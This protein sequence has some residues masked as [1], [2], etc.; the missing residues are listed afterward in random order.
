MVQL[1]NW[2]CAILKCSLLS[3]NP[4]VS[5][6][7]GVASEL[8]DTISHTSVHKQLGHLHRCSASCVCVCVCVSYRSVRK[9]QQNGFNHLNL[10]LNLCTTTPDIKHFYVS[11]A[12]CIY[13]P[14]T[15]LTTKSDYFLTQPLSE[16]FIFITKTC[17]VYRAV[18]NESLNTMHVNIHLY[19]LYH[20]SGGQ[21]SA[22]Y[23]DVVGSIPCHS[24]WNLWRIRWHWDRSF[25]KYEACPESKDTSRVGR[26]GNFL[27]LLWQ[28][29]RR[30]W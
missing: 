17:H 22:F 9:L 18:R 20:G 30:P 3:L 15:D 5:R 29:W 6:I 21:S 19:S 7:P 25:S 24:T 23:R 12:Q 1:S 16:W 11:P 8:H 4:R 2:R 10:L 26:W 13:V 28:H 27:C 14:R